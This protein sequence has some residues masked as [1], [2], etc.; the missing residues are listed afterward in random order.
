MDLGHQP[1]EILRVVGQ[2]VEVGGIEIVRACRNISGIENDVER[3]AAAQRNRVRRVVQ[4]VSSLVSQ[5]LGVVTD[6]L[7]SN[8]HGSQ[9]LIFRNVQAGYPQKRLL[10]LLEV[11]V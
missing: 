2:V 9:R 8:A 5:K 3:L 7:H 11:D 10:A 4:V 6:N 1:A